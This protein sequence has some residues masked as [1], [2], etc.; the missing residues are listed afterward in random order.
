MLGKITR[1][2][3]GYIKIDK[4]KGKLYLYDNAELYYLDMRIE[5]GYIVLDYNKNEVSAGRI[6][7]SSGKL[8]QP[9]FS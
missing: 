5:G 6:K 4:A 1:N 3:K 7:D 2:A 9:S 8:I